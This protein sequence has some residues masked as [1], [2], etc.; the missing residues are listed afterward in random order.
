MSALP[1]RRVD[2]I[3][4]GILA[5]SVHVLDPDDVEGVADLL[6]DPVRGGA[7]LGLR[8]REAA[9]VDL[10]WADLDTTTPNA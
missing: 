10:Q 2:N 3:G 4:G 1:L 7:V 6:L 9:V 8:Q 5:G